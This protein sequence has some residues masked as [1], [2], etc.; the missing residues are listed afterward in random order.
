MKLQKHVSRKVG[1]REYSKWVLVVPEEII[2]KAQIQEG[3]VLF[4]Q[5]ASPGKLIFTTQKNKSIRS[6]R[7]EPVSNKAIKNLNKQKKIMRDELIKLIEKKNMEG[8]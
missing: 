3:S 8:A 6:T 5:V 4:P 7:I 2:R 1:G